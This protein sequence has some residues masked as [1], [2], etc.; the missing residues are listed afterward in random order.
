MTDD[1][2]VSGE[3]MGS[4]R[5]TADQFA[6]AYGIW[7]LSNRVEA[8]KLSQLRTNRASNQVRLLNSH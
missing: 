1:T 4:Q 3:Q 7:S 5:G 2:V 6:T 8:D